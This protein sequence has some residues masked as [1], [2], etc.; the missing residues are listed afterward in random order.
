MILS[1][2]GVSIAKASITDTRADSWGTLELSAASWLGGQGVDVYSNGATAAGP[3]T[4]TLNY[5]NNSQGVSTQ[6]GIEWQCVELVNRLYLTKGWITA[7]WA[8]DGSSLKDNLP[9]GF[10]YQANGS[11]TNLQ[12]GDVIT[13]SGNTTGHASIVE[14]ISGNTVT[15]VNQ[16]TKA[17]YGTSTLS[18]GTLSNWLGSPYSIQGVVHRPTSTGG[19]GTTASRPM[20]VVSSDSSGLQWFIRNS[21]SPGAPDVA[22]FYYGGPGLIPVMGDWD[23]NGT[24]TIGAVARTSNGLLWY[25]KNSNGPGNPDY[26]PFYYGGSSLVPVVGDWNGDKYTTIGVV[27]RTSNGLQWYLRNNNTGGSPD[28]T[29][30]YYGGPSLTPLVGNWDGSGG[31]SIGAVDNSSN[32]WLW[33]LKNSNGSGNPDIA[34]FY[35]G[36]STLIPVS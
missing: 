36:G 12:A 35:Y 3:P 28:Y 27:A 31:D 26:T 7:R 1:L 9:S 2:G 16:N 8:G 33:Y 32:Q 24:V 5:V 21:H 13:F 23:G 6:T 17:V 30:F 11:I 22:P 25:L 10:T 14:S 34:P 20:T 15:T 18:N 19:G 4:D 29:P